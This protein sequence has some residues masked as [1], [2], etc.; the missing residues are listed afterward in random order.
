M[1]NFGK[2]CIDYVKWESK[3]HTIKVLGLLTGN[4]L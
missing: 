4:Y 3:K 1:V 2:N